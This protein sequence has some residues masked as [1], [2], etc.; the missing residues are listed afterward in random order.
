M[1]VLTPNHG[2][3]EKHRLGLHIE[4][5]CQH[6]R[7]AVAL[8]KWKCWNASRAVVCVSYDVTTR[9]GRAACRLLFHI[10]TVIVVRFCIHNSA[11]T[12]WTEPNRKH[13]CCCCCC[14]LLLLLLLLLLSLL[15]PSLLLFLLLSLSLLLLLLSLLFLLLRF[16]LLL[17][18]WTWTIPRP[19]LRPPDRLSPRPPPSDHL[20]WSKLFLILQPPLHGDFFPEAKKC[21]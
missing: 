18:C 9:K 20:S 1:E 4:R 2:S 6:V 10:S 12:G 7:L 3:I 11:R 5:Q 19:W 16:L 21:M 8:R 14:L 17:L 13:N 15:M